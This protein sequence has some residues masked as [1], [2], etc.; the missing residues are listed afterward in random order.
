MDAS[1]FIAGRLRFR[2]RIVMVS[3]AVSYLVMIVAVAVSS[4]FRS[5]IRTGLSSVTGDVRLTPPDL[6]VFDENRPIEGHP[7]YLPYVEAVDGV[8]EVIPVI[9]RAGIVK[10]DDSIH[11]VIFKGIPKE[12]L[13]D[14]H[15][16]LALGVSIPRRLAEISGLEVGDRM[17]SYFVGK[18]V[19]ARQ[20]NVAAIHDA[21]V[22][23]DQN[24]VVH[25]SLSDMQ[26]L[27]AWSEDEV[28]CFEILLEPGYDDE[29][30]IAYACAE[31]GTTVNAYSDDDEE[32]VIA[33]SSIDSYPQL[34]DWLNLIDFN[35]F[36]VL[37]LMTVVA[38][39]NMISGLLIMLFENI[40]TIGLFKSLGMTDKAISKV[41]LSSSSVLVLKGMA[42]GNGLAFLF[43]LIQGATHIL[44]L[45]PE[46]Y[47]VSFV[48]VS[49]DLGMILLADAASFIGIMLL[50]LI[51]C[52][53]ISK[54][55]PA[56]TVRMK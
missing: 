25:A 35:V 55:D 18:T 9:Y 21:I 45:N 28:S 49:P 10:N 31:I 11:G 51:P 44:K 56:E 27:N 26:R 47:F 32:T 4:G 7:A 24:L 36:L 15:D 17:L 46:N 53:F 30:D 50:L 12:M 37:L 2:R 5:E 1:F 43:C 22:E 41:F 29:A 54:V 8:D 33:T 39:F 3:I 13:T 16:T 52:M 19:K 42:W 14:V 38:G 48:P 34:F 23:L 6:N 40:S 20:F